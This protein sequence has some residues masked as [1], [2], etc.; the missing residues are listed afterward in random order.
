MNRDVA[1]YLSSYRCR[2]VS[3][4]FLNRTPELFSNLVFYRMS[5]CPSLIIVSVYFN[6][7]FFH[8]RYFFFFPL[9]L[10]IP[11][12]RDACPQC[13]RGSNLSFY[14]HSK[15]IFQNPAI[16]LP[17]CFSE[18]KVNKL[19]ASLCPFKL[20]FVSTLNFFFSIVIPV[21]TGIQFLFF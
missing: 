15:L 13:N 4:F 17:L 19:T 12:G 18:E 9:S 5:P 16:P 7:F 2:T 10:R 14:H 1:I 11:T 3:S 8:T 6:N 21:K 20:S